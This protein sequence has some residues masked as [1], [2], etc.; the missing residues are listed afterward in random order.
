MNANINKINFYSNTYNYVLFETISDETYSLENS[1]GK[2]YDY[3]FQLCK[4]KDRKDDTTLFFKM[5]DI[6]KVDIALFNL[7]NEKIKDVYLV[8]EKNKEE[9]RF[10]ITKTKYEIS[11]YQLDCYLKQ[12]SELLSVYRNNSDYYCYVFKKIVI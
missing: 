8:I 4:T 3:P 9:C 12:G 6:E 1:R 5:S 2:I 7:L 10:E 11:E